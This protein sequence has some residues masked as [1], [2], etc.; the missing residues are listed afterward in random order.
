MKARFISFHSKDYAASKQFYEELVGLPVAQEYEGEPHRFTNYDLGGVVLK[1]FEWSEG[2]YGSGHSGLFI[3]TEDIDA[4]V[5][6][7]QAVGFK[8]TDIEVHGWGGRSSSVTDP[9][10]NIFSLL[11]AHQP[12]DS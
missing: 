1:V 10:G 5:H 9:S 2:W 11:D 3:E 4:V 6:R 7:I 8:A 12:G